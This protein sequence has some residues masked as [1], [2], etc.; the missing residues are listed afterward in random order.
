MCGTSILHPSSQA[1]LR[2]CFR[3]GGEETVRAKGSELMG[4]LNLREHTWG[5][6][7]SRI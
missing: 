6:E 3:G 5:G 2:D 4:I 1:R 7:R